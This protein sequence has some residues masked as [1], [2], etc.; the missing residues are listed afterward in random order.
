M[1]VTLLAEQQ[2]SEILALEDMTALRVGI[3]GAGCAGLQYE[4]SIDNAQEGDIIIDLSDGSFQVVIDPISMAYLGEAILDFND[5]D[6]FNKTFVLNNPNAKM[7][8]GCG[9][10]FSM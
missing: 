9:T 3:K 1:K 2:I 8:C 7:T 4:F 5:D 10:S 6:P